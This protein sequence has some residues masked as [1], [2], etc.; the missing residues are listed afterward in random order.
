MTYSIIISFV[1]IFPLSVLD[2]HKLGSLLYWGHA[3]SLNLYP[4]G[5]L[6]D[7]PLGMNLLVYTAVCTKWSYAAYNRR[8]FI[9]KATQVFTSTTAACHPANSSPSRAPTVAPNTVLTAW[10]WV[11]CFVWTHAQS[12]HVTSFKS[13]DAQTAQQIMQDQQTYKRWLR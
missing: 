3:L 11:V 13:G 1:G 9:L 6:D 5:C 2:H 7:Y 4:L 8:C 10:G 12:R